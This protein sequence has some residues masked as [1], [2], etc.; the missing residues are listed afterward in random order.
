M[1][2]AGVEKRLAKFRQNADA[3]K[4]LIAFGEAK[5]RAGLDPAELAAYATAANVILNLD[6]AV[7][8]E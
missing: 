2:T 5:P 7:T 4:Q 8:R 1:L 3:A 6:E